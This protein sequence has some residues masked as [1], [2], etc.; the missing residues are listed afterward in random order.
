MALEGAR[1]GSMTFLEHLEE[2]RA[3]LLH[4]IGALA[5]AFGIC[6]AFSA[7]LYEFLARPVMSALPAGRT[8][9]FTS[10]P[11]PFILYMKVALLAGIFLCSPYI[12]WQLWLFVSPGLYGHERRLAL[13][14]IFFSTALFVA[15]GA[16]G[17][18]IAFPTACRFFLSVG[19][20]FE[21]ILTIREYFRLE[22]QVLLAMGLVFELPVLI[23]FFSRLG[24]I[25]PQFLWAKFSYA[26]LVIFILAAIITP[27]DFVSQLMI[28][29][30]MIVLYLVGIS[31][32]WLF[33]PKD[34]PDERPPSGGTPSDDSA[35][36]SAPE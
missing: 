7:P 31:V 18:S 19:Q 5:I 21:P 29:L 11:D 13:P 17:Y 6:W 24:I 15:G 34:R 2:L 4:S 14:F 16:S 25:T 22:M 28:G 27:P 3:R 36:D 26:V 9:A 12:L 23:F 32:A 1:V 10:L 30:P 35:K 8:L 33:G 20:P